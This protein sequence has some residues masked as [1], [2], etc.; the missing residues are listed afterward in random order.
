MLSSGFSSDQ[1]SINQD[2]FLRCNYTITRTYMGADGTPRSES[3]NFSAEVENDLEC[4][5][6]QMNHVWDLRL[7]ARSW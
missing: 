6:T 1:S 7:G 5:W 4:T 2:E 3:R